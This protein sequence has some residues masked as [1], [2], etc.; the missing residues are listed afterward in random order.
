MG[1]TSVRRVQADFLLARYVGVLQISV[2]SMLTMALRARPMLYTAY[3]LP[4]IDEN[5]VSRATTHP[6]GSPHTQQVRLKYRFSRVARH[7]LEPSQCGG[8][9]GALAALCPSSPALRF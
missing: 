7:G 6:I 2:A 5:T 1:D 3:F 8:H 4:P 9:C